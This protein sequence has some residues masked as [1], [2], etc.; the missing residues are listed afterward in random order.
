MGTRFAELN[1]LAYYTL[2]GLLLDVVLWCLGPVVD[3]T[4]S[5]GRLRRC[6]AVATCTACRSW[7]RISD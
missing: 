6:L 5:Y 7:Y 2:V 4:G 3:D 1:L